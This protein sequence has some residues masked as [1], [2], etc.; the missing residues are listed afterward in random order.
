M[1]AS[2]QT[3]G[4]DGE[5]VDHTHARTPA[6]GGG[7]PLGLL[8]LQGRAGNAAVV[9]M[10]RQAGHSWAA[11]E[12]QHGAGCGHG[13]AER[14]Q[15]QR[16]TVHDVLRGSGTPLDSAT[17]ADMEAR[18]GADFS[19]VRI[20]DDSAAR[21]S[22]AEVGARA[23]TSGSHVVIGDGGADKHTLAHELT[24]VIQQRQGP[25]A[26]TDNGDGL[27]VSD[28]SD[29]FERE[30]ELNAR[31]V[32]S[33]A[34]APQAEPGHETGPGS[35]RAGVVQRMMPW[36]GNTGNTMSLDTDGDVHMDSDSQQTAYYGQSS[37]GS[38]T[39]TPSQFMSQ[40]QDLS[41]S[42]TG[43]FSSFGGSFSFSQP[44]RGTRPAAATVAREQQA[45]EL[46][47]L[48]CM[49]IPSVNEGAA[50]GI[51][52]TKPDYALNARAH[53]NHF[54]ATLL[55]R[56][57]W[58]DVDVRTRRGAL[59]GSYPAFYHSDYFIYKIQLINDFN[60]PTSINL[61][62]PFEV[63]SQSARSG[64]RGSQGRAY[65]YDHRWG[66]NLD[67]WINPLLGS[68]DA[69]IADHDM[70]TDK[71]DDDPGPEFEALP[72]S[73]DQPFVFYVETGLRDTRFLYDE[74]DFKTAL[75]FD[76][77]YF[78]KELSDPAS[79]RRQTANSIPP[80]D[81]RR[82]AGR[83]T[84]TAMGGTQAHQ[85]MAANGSAGGSQG[86]LAKYEWCHL[87]GDGD[88]GPNIPANLVVGTNAVNTE[89]LAME[90]GLRRYRAQLDNEGLAI[91]LDVKATMQHAPEQNPTDPLPLQAAWISYQI[92]V[93]G[94]NSP[95]RQLL[96]RQ[97]MDAERG[98]ITE[99]EFGYLQKKVENAI[100]G[101]IE[102][103]LNQEPQADDSDAE[104][105]GEV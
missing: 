86:T 84:A 77:E 28:P 16:S 82:S 46:N 78:Q 50:G 53:L 67:F 34:P 64:G 61:N 39:P 6:P 32:M 59:H 29:R 93:V 44:L 101:F 36:P 90:T 1:R 58:V 85:W 15:V 7:T 56:E 87:I 70:D 25:V 51:E 37:Q 99:S 95:F 91:E 97:I 92:S 89:Q 45:A 72:T 8:A 9:Q 23:Y 49:M 104:S 18:L 41:Q 62:G 21:A 48:D 19:D 103:T 102:T 47:S 3:R 5:R 35:G 52:A 71:R 33:T 30:A 80:S 96:H 94:K 42:S 11:E 17:R 55:E 40:S 75:E 100:K 4:P 81:D 65:L 27:K 10:L 69:F 66:L 73:P 63:L 24:H 88:N 31:R 38:S 98:T 57:R 105:D 26:G 83:S 60:S 54:G 20:H 76:V 2:E 22:A 13:T 74:R 12:H 68:P 14:P 43:S 79:V